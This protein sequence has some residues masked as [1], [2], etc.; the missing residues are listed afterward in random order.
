MNIVAGCLQERDAKGSDSDVAL[1]AF[2]PRYYTRDNK[3]GGAPDDIVGDSAPTIAFAAGQ[4]EP[5]ADSESGVAYCLDAG[6]GIQGVMRSGVRRLTPVE[7]CRLQ[8]FP[9]DW[10]DGTGLS[11]SAMYRTL[12]NAVAVPVVEWIGK[13]LVEVGRG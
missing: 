8:G 2:Q 5:N 11:D 10:F 13:R 9:D 1:I 4:G 3:T 12:G 7:C 6:R